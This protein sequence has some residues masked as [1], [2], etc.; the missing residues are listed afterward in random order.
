MASTHLDPDRLATAVVSDAAIVS[1]QLAAAGLGEPTPLLP[2]LLNNHALFAPQRQP[3][4]R[5]GGHRRYLRG[6]LIWLMLSDPVTVA[7][8]VETGAVG[9]LVP[10]LAKVIYKALLSLL[11]YL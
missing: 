1:P 3:V 11:D 10:E 8:A 6:A 2:R 5:G 9:P 4:R 7:D